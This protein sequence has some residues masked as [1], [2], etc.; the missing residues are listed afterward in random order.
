MSIETLKSNIINVHGSKGTSWIKSLDHNL[1]FL[2]K[3]WHLSDITPFDNL[4]YHY[5]AKAHHPHIGA[6]VL[7]FGPDPKV[8]THELFALRHFDG[9]GC[10]RVYDFHTPL[11]AL[12]LEAAVPGTSLLSFL[13]DQPEQTLQ[14]Y[15]TAFNNLHTNATSPKDIKT[16]HVNDWLSSLQDT[17]LNLLPDNIKTKTIQIVDHLKSLRD[18]HHFL[19]GDL[20]ADNVIQHG[21]TW[22]IID[23]KGVVGELAFEA[24]CF[25]FVTS[26]ELTN[27]ADIECILH[28]RIAQLAHLINLTPEHLT[29]WVFIR[30]ALHTNWHLQDK[31]N[32]KRNYLMCQLLMGRV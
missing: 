9:N 12:L 10:I 24:S 15:A 25:E 20:H 14:Y 28:D 31:T 19:H 1:D 30:N 13:E 17:S 29:Q 23:P 7:K 4:S 16:R 32:P 5:V 21:N 22:K 26:Y 3:H 2:K 18:N 27:H 8:Y 6:I 11:C